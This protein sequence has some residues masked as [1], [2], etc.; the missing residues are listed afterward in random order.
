MVGDRG[1]F[2]DRRIGDGQGWGKW[3]IMSRKRK[4]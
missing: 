3:R 2:K 1:R 4:R